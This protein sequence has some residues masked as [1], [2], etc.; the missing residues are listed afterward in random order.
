MAK[1]RLTITTVTTTAVDLVDES[2]LD[3]LSLSAVARE[4]GVGPS[5]LYT[6]CDGLEGLRHL[7]A[8]A[9]TNNLT[10]DL[11]TAAIGNAGHDAL[12]AMGD[13]YRRFAE[14]HPGQFASTL[15]PPDPSHE[16]LQAA[17]ALLL[18]VFTLVFAAM[19]L[20]GEDSTRAARSTRSAIHGFLAIEHLTGSPD[21]GSDDFQHLLDTLRDGLLG[22]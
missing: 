16:E 9:A 8:V 3:A 11:Q 18:E 6:H 7:V 12:D 4:L 5:A 14:S 19:G 15:R 13:A 2:G 20:A 17:T 10:R 1:V 22:R 21:G